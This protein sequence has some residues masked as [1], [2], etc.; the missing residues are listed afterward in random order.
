MESGSLKLLETSGPHRACNG[1]LL[2][3][4]TLLFHA[5]CILLS[6][7]IKLNRS[8]GGNLTVLYCLLKYDITFL[9]DKHSGIFLLEL[10]RILRYFARYV[11]NNKL[12]T[13]NNKF[14]TIG[15][16]DMQLVS[17]SKSQWIIGKH[18]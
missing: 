9:F 2:P 13:I 14:I 10:F 1:T 12:L 11:F 8:T 17:L 4:F 16:A 7:S 15:F 3:F 5:Q 6:L 18:Y